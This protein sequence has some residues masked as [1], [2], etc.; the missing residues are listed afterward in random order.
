[1]TDDPEKDFELNDDDIAQEIESHPCC[2][3]CGERIDQ[4]SAVKLENYGYVCD[5][6]LENSREEL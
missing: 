1:M 3:I 2:E 5:S 6:C 4:E